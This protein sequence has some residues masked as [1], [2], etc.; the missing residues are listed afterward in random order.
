M[1][2]P[3]RR[4]RYVDLSALALILVGASLCVVATDRLH[5]IAQLS[6]RHPGPRSESALV[7]ADRARD[8]AYGG[9]GLIASGFL[10]AVG[11]AIRVARRT[12]QIAN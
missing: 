3:L 1:A 5:D 7:A 10:V 4:D 9:A 6:Y 2:T 11:S 8:L 12:R